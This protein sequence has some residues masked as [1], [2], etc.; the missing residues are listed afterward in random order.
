V[1]RQLGRT[2]GLTGFV[3]TGRHRTVLTALLPHL[4]DFGQV[5]WKVTGAAIPLNWA[6]GLQ[7]LTARQPPTM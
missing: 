1:H 5:N 2:A 6:D 7:R 4:R 3:K